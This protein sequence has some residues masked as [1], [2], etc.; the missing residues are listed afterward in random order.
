MFPDS[1]PFTTLTDFPSLGNLP[2]TLCHYV[3]S[4]NFSTTATCCSPIVATFPSSNSVFRKSIFQKSIVLDPVMIMDCLSR[5]LTSHAV[6][7]ELD[8][9]L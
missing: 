2:G 8:Q 7:V 6:V 1:D 3:D 4:L 9:S 5:N